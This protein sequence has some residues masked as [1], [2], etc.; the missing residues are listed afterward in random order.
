MECVC[1][2]VLNVLGP[3]PHILPLLFLDSMPWVPGSKWPRSA[4]F[5][6]FVAKKLFNRETPYKE[7]KATHNKGVG[8]MEIGG[9]EPSCST[10]SLIPRPDAAPGGVHPALGPSGS[11][12]AI[13][14]LESVLDL[15][16]DNLGAK[17]A[18][19]PLARG[20]PHTP[21]L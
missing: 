4:L 7:G 18:N 20:R 11:W 8:Q 2:G 6:Y 15:L 17:W 9:W 5:K 14:I 21:S 1:G 10:S 12:S 3:F 19:L 16:R 13:S